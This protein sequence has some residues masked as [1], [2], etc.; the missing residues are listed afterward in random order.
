VEKNGKLHLRLKSDTQPHR[1]QVWT[2]N[3]DTRDFRDS[4]FT[5][6]PMSA[7]GDAHLYELAIP[8]SGYAAL[9]GEAV[10]NG[11]SVPFQL[12]TNVRIVGKQTTK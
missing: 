9:L 6:H 4:Q 8:E 11:Q 3:S 12:S 10:F 2:A 5:S 1:V 7:D